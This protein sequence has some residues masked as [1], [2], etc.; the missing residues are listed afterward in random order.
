MIKLRDILNEDKKS[1]NEV[2]V[3]DDLIAAGLTLAIPAIFTKVLGAIKNRNDYKRW[4]TRPDIMMMD[5]LVKDDEWVKM[6]YND[7]K[8]DND[9]IKAIKTH[10]DYLNAK[11]KKPLGTVANKQ[12]T[13][14]AE[15]VKKWLE[16]P[17]AEKALQNVFKKKFPKIDPNSGKRDIPNATGN[18]TYPMWRRSALD[19]ANF[20]FVQSLHSGNTINHLNKWAEKN[21]LEKVDPKKPRTITEPEKKQPTKDKKEPTKDKKTS[22]K[23]KDMLPKTALDQKIKNPETGRNIKVK[24]ALEYDKDKPVYK[25]AIKL[26]KNK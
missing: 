19:S 2:F 6:V 10:P 23:L 21:K 3:I 24:S 14:D 25:A 11:G 16:N 1:I 5:E 13:Y 20:R 7:I 4:L 15:M 12:N 18:I 8:N 9:T 26:A 22:S 17:I